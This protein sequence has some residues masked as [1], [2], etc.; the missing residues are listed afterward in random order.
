MCFLRNCVARSFFVSK[1]E[2]TLD[3]VLRMVHKEQEVALDYIPKLD[4][5]VF[6][7]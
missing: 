5:N 2:R 3:V 4:K 1:G 7:H 6:F